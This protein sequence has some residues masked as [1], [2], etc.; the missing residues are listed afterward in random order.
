MLGLFAT[1]FIVLIAMW[2][3][4]GRQITPDP[5]QVVLTAFASR[6][7]R[8]IEGLEPR[9]FYKTRDMGVLTTESL[10]ADDVDALVA[11]L[12]KTLPTAHREHTEQD[13]FVIDAWRV[14]DSGPGLQVTLIRFPTESDKGHI[15]AVVRSWDSHPVIWERIRRWLGQ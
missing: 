10:T 12:D 1:G 15:E 3:G 14:E 4:A 8:S 7:F 5:A 6:G 2:I 13:G 9:H 11:S